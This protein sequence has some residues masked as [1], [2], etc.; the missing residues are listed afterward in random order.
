M[1]SSDVNVSASL[2]SRDGN[3]SF[4]PCPPRNMQMKRLYNVLTVSFN[5]ILTRPERKTFVRV[6][7]RFLLGTDEYNK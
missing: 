6:C 4:L 1:K 2:K 3:I 7:E 5:L